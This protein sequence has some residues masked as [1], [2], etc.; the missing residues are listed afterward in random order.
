MA[1]RLLV[2][3]GLSVLVVACGASAPEPKAKPPQARMDPAVASAPSC[4]RQAPG[5]GAKRAYPVA[6]SA[7]VALARAG[8]G[9]MLAYIV[10]ADGG[11]LHTVDVGAG[12]ELAVTELKGKPE[13]VLVLS[14]GRVAVTLRDADLVEVLEPVAAAGSPLLSRCTA[15]LPAEP[16]AMAET[17]DGRGLLVTSGWAAQLT[18]LDA[19]TL[20]VVSQV[21]VAREPRAVVVSDDGRRAFVSHLVNATMSIVE[22]ADAAKKPRELALGV[23]KVS[24]PN[25][26]RSDETRRGC[27]GYTLAKA[28]DVNDKP[29]EPAPV[30]VESPPVLIIP[31][32]PTKPHAV[33]PPRAPLPKP[34]PAP[35]RV[36]AP[37]VTVDPG[38]AGRVAYYGSNDG[39]ATEEPIVSVIDERAERVLTRS[40]LAV[41]RVTPKAE[42]SCL[43]PRGAAYA[44]GSLYVACLGIDAIVE[45]DA[46]AVDPARAERRRWSVPSG[47]MGVA[48]DLDG[49]RL[50][51][52]SQF[53]RAVSIVP[54]GEAARTV[55]LSLS[56]K[57]GSGPTGAV[58]LGRALYH[59]TGDRR[60]SLEGMSCASC[61]P[62]GREDAITW[63]TIE[64]PRQTPML[65]GRLGDTAPFSW[66]GAHATVEEHLKDTIGRLRGT[67]MPPNELEAIAAYMASLEGP[68]ARKAKPDRV[69]LVAQ[70]A[71]LFASAET[72][73]A[74]C[75]VPDKG[76]QDGLSHDVD[77][78][79]APGQKRALDTP[80]LRFLAGTAPYFH[81]GRYAT[82]EAMLDAG[83]HQMGHAS[84]LT[85]EQRQALAAYL[86]TL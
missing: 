9:A 18:T 40:T 55:T 70:G 11:T 3:T 24:A 17:P 6:G 8:D 52:W 62:D 45:L 39:L 25:V 43:L 21:D 47:P 41:A 12:K 33:P 63:G 37:M 4:A 69:A 35:G 36:F 85:R 44:K 7:P 86:E 64:G 56:R 81:D 80:S 68:R 73:C 77:L 71:T 67:G 5:V 20:A 31:P 32:Q 74:S 51:A 54:L 2:G 48:V 53:D 10:D 79:V 46:R 28:I 34:Q 57:A 66:T 61:H 50:V 26:P 19:A 84:Q 30:T 23:K 78:V 15:S 42:A 1:K 22:L 72:G 82:L 76:F 13:H 38:T 75:H 60:I 29:G 14:D 83:D 59:R 27:Q 65:T 49:D 58:A 16:I